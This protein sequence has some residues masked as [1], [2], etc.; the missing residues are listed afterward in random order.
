MR[1]FNARWWSTEEWRE[2]R[3][4]DAGEVHGVEVPLSCG[5]HRDL[6]TN[7]FAPQCGQPIS[8]AQFAAMRACREADLLVQPLIGPEPMSPFWGML[9]AFR[10]LSG[11]AE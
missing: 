2:K 6:V 7:P 9:N 3:L 8:T 10:V 5:E 11:L 1:K 4:R